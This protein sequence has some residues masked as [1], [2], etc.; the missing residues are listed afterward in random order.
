MKNRITI[1][2]MAALFLSAGLSSCKKEEIKPLDPVVA[3]DLD[4]KAP[5]LNQGVWIITSFQWKLR[6]QNN[7][8][9]NYEFRFGANGIVYASHLGQVSTGKWLKRETLVLIDFGDQL[10]LKELNN[11]HWEITRRFHRSIQLKG[12]SPY[13]NKSEFLV[14]KKL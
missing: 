5:E 3:E 12:L 8:F 11:K 1:A 7:H 14:I 10:P 9:N 2:A 6:E 4:S 13:D